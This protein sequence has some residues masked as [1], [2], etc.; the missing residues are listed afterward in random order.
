[1]DETPLES[2][3]ARHPAPTEDFAPA[4][5]E[6]IAEKVHEEWARLRW[7]QGWRYG[8]TR[9]KQSKTTP[10]LVSYAELPESEKEYDRNAARTTLRALRAAGYRIVADP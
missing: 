10:N 1:M 2:N 5:I 8:P 3:R 7:E 6:R 9:D 4:L